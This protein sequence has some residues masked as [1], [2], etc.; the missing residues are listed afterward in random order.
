M[1]MELFAGLAIGLVVALIAV[2]VVMRGK[3][4]AVPVEPVV[5]PHPTLT[6]A[7][8]R[9]VIREVHSETLGSIADQSKRDREEVVSLATREMG[10]AI[11]DTK[12]LIDGK[13]SDLES[14]IQK[15]REMNTEKFG[16]MDNAVAGLALQTQALNKVLSSS[17]GRGNW[18]EKMLEDLLMKSGFERGINYEMQEK[19][20]GGGKPDFTF[21]LP[22]DRVLYLDSKFPMENYLKYFEAQDDNTRKIMKD[23]FF[24]NVKQRIK[25]LE[26]RDYV[27]QSKA[28]AID[29][30]L[31][32][33]P[34]EGVL[35]FIQ[36][37]SPSL[38]DEAV[39]KRVVLCSPLTLY[40]FL[41]V[42]RQATA[43]FH[44][45]QNANEVLRLITSF[46]KAWGA[47]I[48]NL[49]EMAASF[50]NMQK[51]LKAVTTG[52]VFTAVS[53]PLREIEE[54]AKKRGVLADESAMAE[55]DAAM[56]EV[57]AESEDEE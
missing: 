21:Y 35:G 22:P 40:A 29:Y 31:L 54:I 47:Y 39:S 6:A 33:I 11:N 32:F 27:D 24:E 37:H 25:E 15:L 12:D 56:A 26:T 18:G 17:Q 52:K 9:E 23:A 34:N 1:N 50:N 48:R 41:G 49:K 16:S 30:V 43:S 20:D 46:T 51:K 3:P 45:E 13:V 7:E 28:N 19:L 5:A 2:I 55:L 4:K 8:I 57:E 42:V 44:M 38:I 36:Q 14:E 10:K 53:K